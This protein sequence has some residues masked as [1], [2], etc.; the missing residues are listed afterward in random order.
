LAAEA[1]VK[2]ATL[3]HH[4]FGKPK[5][6]V[7]VA[8]SVSE[9]PI[10]VQHAE[11]LA[12]QGHDSVVPLYEALFDR[13]GNPLQPPPTAELEELIKRAGQASQPDLKSTDIINGQPSGRL[14]HSR[15]TRTHVS[16]SE[17]SKTGLKPFGYITGARRHN[18]GDSRRAK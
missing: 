6:G 16:T 13:D 5:A 14:D 18:P 11:G 4:K 10:R 9:R 7:N 8:P 3:A 15:P 2:E 12:R 1:S 17:A